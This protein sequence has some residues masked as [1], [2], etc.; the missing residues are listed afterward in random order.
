MNDLK[1]WLE[2]LELGQYARV[3]AENDVDLDVLH[4]LSDDD[5]RELGL[6]LGHRRRLLA[7]LHEAPRPAGTAGSGLAQP[8]SA[9]EAEEDAERRQIT[10]L[11]CDL[12]GSTALSQR[13]DPEELREVMR[14]YHDTVAGAVAAYDGHV[15]KLLGDGVLAYFGWPHAHEAQ[16]EMAIRAALEAV[17]AVGGLEAAGAPLAARAAIATGPVVIGDMIGKTAHEHGAVVGAT[18]NLAARLQDLAEPGEVAIDAA[19][20]RLAGGSFVLA[21]GGEHRLKGFADPVAVWRVTSAART[22]SRFDALH[23]A[24]LTDFVGRG[25]EIGLLVDRWQEARDGEGQVV[26][27]SGEA[28]IGKSRILVEFTSG[29]AAEDCRILRYQCSPHEVNAAFQ[30]IVSE[31]EAAAA[32]VPD[33]DPERRLDKLEQHLAEVFDETEDATALI[34]ALLS[35]PLERFPPIDMAPQRRKQVT[36]ARLTER[37]AR[38]SRDRPIV[39][40]VED[41]HWIDPS[42]LET[43]DALVERV[44]DL[45]VLMV[46]TYRPEFT[47]P[48]AGFGHVTA[49]SLNRLGRGDGR[50]IVERTAGGK[51]LPD[52]VLERILEQTDG[53]PLFVEEL[54]KTVLEAGFLEEQDDRYVLTGP[55]P[56][57]AIPTTLQ[58][59]LMA[60]LDRLAQVKRVIQAAACIGREFSA[61]LLAAALPIDDEGL[62]RAFE[63]LLSAQLIFRRGSVDDARYIFKHALVQDA[64]YASLLVSARQRLHEQLALALERTEDPDPLELARHFAH[65]GANDRAVELYVA[66]GRKS[67]EASALPEAIGALELGLQAVETLPAAAERDRRELI[68]RV[69]LGA[70]RMANFGWAYPSVA[71]ALE[72]AFPLARALAQRDALGSILWGLW[73][74]YQTRTNFPRAHEW[75]SEL[76]VVANENPKSD[77]PVVYDMSA[78]CQCFWEADYTRAIGHTDHLM[79]TYDPERHAGIVGLTNHD[80]LVFAQHWAGSLADWIRGYPERSVERLEEAVALAR[81]I[82]HPFNLVFALTAGAT[83]LIYLDEPDRLLALCDEAEKVVTEE[84]LGPFSA[85]VNVMQW[86]GGAQVQHGEFEVGY[87]LAKKGNDFWNASGGRVCNAMFR[88][89]IVRGL[90]GL[91]RIDEAI[92]LNGNNITHCRETGDRYMEPEC[93]RLQGE[94]TLAAEP[95]DVAAAERHFR[96]AIDTAQAHGAKSW[97]LRAA[98][99]L[100]QL[101]GD[102][103]RG[104]EAT[105]SLEPVLAW[106]SE[107]SETEDLRQAAK[108]LT[109]LA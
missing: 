59:S 44:Q 53:I 1:A 68:I 70:A 25:Q 63:Q 73:V 77:L 51:A 33:D 74:H 17:A 83:S 37:V 96:E 50:T 95:A 84:A 20:R 13:I 75:L 43:L 14:R 78:G 69:A 38:L 22:D 57:L 40:L 28:G 60:R 2:K 88:S 109:A 71:D 61:N 55:L 6:S 23:G 104:D 16:A 27:I 49:H 100:A 8:D 93:L 24:G 89:W 94:L 29:L 86:R 42:S 87:S 81:K 103:D 90:Q 64:A 9:L 62:E 66:A 35:L 32:I 72:P 80:P 97:E 54:T 48:W 18:P 56:A 39:L 105:A 7:A 91:G 52:E 45:S 106:F 4:H 46:M 12:V 85:H 47:P 65:A 11:F 102:R 76:E 82:G 36:I 41:I 31:I 79:T 99:S 107:G 15:A 98:M 34:A 5:L 58:D 92:L 101:L 26:L 67:L 30:P 19:T 21:D 10:V 108:L 3:L